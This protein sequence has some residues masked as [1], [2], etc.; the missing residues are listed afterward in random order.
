MFTK[1][2]CLFIRCREANP[3]DGSWAALSVR[4]ASIRRNQAKREESKDIVPP[5]SAIG[6]FNK[7]PSYYQMIRDAKCTA[8]RSILIDH[9]GSKAIKMSGFP[10]V[11]TVYTIDRKSRMGDQRLS[12]VEFKSVEDVESLTKEANLPS[13]SL[14]TN[15]TMFQYSGEIVSKSKFTNVQNDHVTL[16]QDREL[17]D[18]QRYS[19]L[20]ANNTMSLV[21]LKLKFITLINLE[22]VLCSGLY[23]DFELMPFGSSVIDVGC[24][25]GDLD[26]VF[27]RK[28]DH[29]SFPDRY[30]TPKLDHSHKSIPSLMHLPKGVGKKSDLKSVMRYFNFMLRD[31][32]PLVDSLSVLPLPHAKV[33]IIKFTSRVTSIDCDLSFDLGLDHLD[34]NCLGKDSGIL[35]SHVLYSLC[36]NNNLFTAVLVCLRTYAKLTGITN[37]GGTQRFTN[38]QLLSLVIFYLQQKPTSMRLENSSDLI[39]ILSEGR[40]LDIFDRILPPLSCILDPKLHPVNW[41]LHIDE[42]QLELIVPQVVRGFFDYYSQFNF[43]QNSLNTHTAQIDKKPDNSPIYVVNPI[44]ATCNVCYNVTHKATDY[45]MIHIRKTLESMKR[46]NPSE[47]IFLAQMRHMT[48]SYKENRMK[49]RSIDGIF[50]DMDQDPNN[51]FV[52]DIC[53]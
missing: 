31:Y 16:S 1:G 39:K 38:F 6:Y 36:R 17:S 47:D 32:V 4:R 53:R 2:R 37:K 52:Y 10:N 26:I 44:D 15:L 28:V 29:K 19:E 27:T 23:G 5:Q 43:N 50:E 41:S 40:K 45:F 18:F 24:D 48:K 22:K 13:G 7:F 33:P 51:E 8:R 11:E 42:N 12:L 25:S 20:I 3:N 9:C 46:R 14:P 35:M 21:A 49:I 34:D 30:Q